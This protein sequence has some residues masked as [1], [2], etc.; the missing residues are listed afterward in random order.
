MSKSKITSV[1]DYLSDPKKGITAAVLLVLVIVA[2]VFVWRKVKGISSGSGS[3]V[4][5]SLSDTEI[6][7]MTGTSVTK[8]T[9]FDSLV[10]RLWNACL[11]IGTNEKEVYAVMGCLNTQADYVKLNRMWAKKWK[12]MGFLAR[13]A[14]PNTIPELLQSE[15]SAKELSMV[16]TILQENGITPDF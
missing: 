3:G 8:S 6:E 11:G 2:V 13:T 5:S 4:A 15:L 9:D 14:L 10:T 12:S 7:V 16:R 1:I